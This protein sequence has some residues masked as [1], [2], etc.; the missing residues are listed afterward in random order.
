MM[1]DSNGYPFY[2]HS[3]STLIRIFVRVLDRP[4]LRVLRLL[5]MEVV[6]ASQA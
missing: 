1:L 2:R 5:K 3:G 6:V 4:G